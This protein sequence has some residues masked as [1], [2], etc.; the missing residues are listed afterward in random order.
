M[1][2]QF[3]LT[4]R[5]RHQAAA[6]P[7]PLV[8]DGLQAGWH[9]R[10]A[11]LPALLQGLAA[12]LLAWPSCHRL[13]IPRPLTLPHCLTLPRRLRPAA[14]ACPQI[15]ACKRASARSI[16]A[17]LPYFGYARADRKTQV[18]YGEASALS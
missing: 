1:L 5:L 12:R 6:Q 3:L 2:L 15:D 14:L 17:V 8:A 7:L 9:G 4:S 16:T 18:S 11:A 13:Q 10:V